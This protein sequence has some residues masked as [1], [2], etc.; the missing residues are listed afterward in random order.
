MTNIYDQHQSAFKFVKAYVVTDKTGNLIA[1]VAFKRSPSNLTLRC[2]FHLIGLQMEAGKARGGGYD[3]AGAAAWDAF[4][5]I[6]LSDQSYYDDF[7]AFGRALEKGAGSINWD[8]CLSEA[9]YNVF[10]AI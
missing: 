6:K 1:R 8:R 4:G 7:V 2:F 10:Q 9:G 3:K 5:K